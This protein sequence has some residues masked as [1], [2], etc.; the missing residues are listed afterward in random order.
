MSVVIDTA[1]SKRITSLRS[2]LTILIVFY[3]NNSIGKA[4]DSGINLP[5]Y[6]IYFRDFMFGICSCVNALFF[7]ISSYLLYTGDTGKRTYLKFIKSK[8]KSL[9]LP[10]LLWTILVIVFYYLAQS[11]K[12]LQPFFTTNIVRQFTVSDWIHAFI[13][14]YAE[15]NN[16]LHAPLIGQFWFLR[17]LIIFNLF[18]LFF[19]KI[20]DKFPV[21]IFFILC[22]IY[23]SDPNMYIINARALA[24]FCFGYYIVKYIRD[25]ESIEIKL[26]D[27]IFLY[28]ILLILNTS[29]ILTIPLASSFIVVVGV[30]FFFCISYYIIKCEKLFIILK[31]LSTYTFYIYATHGIVEEVLIRLTMMIMPANGIIYIIQYFILNTVTILII[32][33]F[34]IL[35]KKVCPKLCKVLNGGR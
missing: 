28:L 15:S 30:I 11:V 16:N 34:C 6:T 2:I 27:I 21:S 32:M 20:I 10:Y 35:L 9:I 12:M 13:G 7:L 3:H 33:T 1:L 18:Y 4:I 26:Y 24:L 14:N 31:R 17:D 5:A 8:F 25:M 22:A 29:K 19:K 23:V